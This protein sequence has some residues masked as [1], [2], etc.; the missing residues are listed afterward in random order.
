MRVGFFTRKLTLSEVSDS[1]DAKDSVKVPIRTLRFKV[2]PEA[3]PWLNAATI[4]ANQVW[5]YFNAVSFKAA[6][7]FAGKPRYLSGFDLC[8]LSAGA[9][10]YFEHIGADTIQRIATEYAIRRAQFKKSKLRWRVSSG[11]R[12]SLGWVPFKAASIRRHNRYLRFCG[13][14]IRV[15]EKERFASISK[16]QSGCFAQDALGDWYL[17]LP[18]AIPDQSPAPELSAVGIDLGLKDT[19]VTSDGERLAAGQFYRSLEVKIAQAQRRGHKRQ[20]KRLHR[21]ACRRRQN[22][23]HQFSRRI[24]NQYQNI[25]IGDVSSLKLVKTRMAKSVLDAGWGILKTQLLY[26]GEY[27]G[28]SVRIVNERNTSRTCS[29]CGSLTGPTGVNGLRVRTWICSGCGALHDRDVN[30]A[31]NILA[32]ERLPPPGYGNEISQRHAPPSRAHRPR[33]ARIARDAA[34]S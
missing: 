26:K 6:R 12:R 19:A 20:A 28:R 9:T 31:R 10:E 3:Y 17:C 24:V 29:S 14:V 27:A 5:N 7:P 4:E 8:N 13:K 30:A 2:R 25:F 15:F 11:S 16:W 32:A 1:E 34:A 22:A 18:V 23:L 21:Q 33:K